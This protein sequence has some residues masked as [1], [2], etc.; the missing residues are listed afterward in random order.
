[1]LVIQSMAATSTHV[2]VGSI[3]GGI[4]YSADGSSWQ[5]ITCGY[6][7]IWAMGATSTDIVFAGTYG[8]GLWKS[9]DGVNFNK[10]EGISAT[11]IYEITVDVNDNIYVS[12][13]EAGIFVSRDGGNTWE[14]LGLGG[15]GVSSILVNMSGNNS[16]SGDIYAGTSEG[17]IYRK[18]VSSITD[19]NTVEAIPTEFGLAQNYPNPF[20]PS[21]VIEFSIAEAGLYVVKIFNVLGQEV[22]TVANQDFAA[23]KYSFNFDASNLTS[24]IYFY[25]LVGEKVNMTKKMLLLK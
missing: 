4:S 20:N 25:K 23:G 19:I 8:E 21:T 7:T 16:A 14:S 22:A 13:W 5:K 1:M 3:G 6:Q 9:T 11:F 24:G 12:S 10:C 15:F 2:Y 17:A 18:S